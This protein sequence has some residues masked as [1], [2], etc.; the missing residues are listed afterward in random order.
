MKRNGLAASL[1]HWTAA[2]LLLGACHN[3]NGPGSGPVAGPGARDPLQGI[4][5]VQQE[6]S[7][8]GPAATVYGAAVQHA[9]APSEQAILDALSHLGVE[10]CPALSKM[11]REVARVAP[12]HVNIPPKLLDALMAWA[13]LPYPQ[14]RLVLVQLP[15]DPDECHRRMGPSCQ[16]AIESLVQQVERQMPTDSDHVCVGAGVAPAAGGATRLM[17]AVLE[18]T[19]LLE[20]MATTAAVGAQI[21]LA[22][23]LIEGR[24]R[25]TIE[26]VGPTGRMTSMPVSVSVDGSFR[27][28]VPCGPERGV[29]QVEVLAEG[30]HGPE[31]AANFPLH[32]GVS[33]PKTLTVELERI[34][35]DVRPQQLAHANFSYLNEERR[36]RGLPEL[37]WD[38][39]AADVATKHS[40]D[41]ARNGFVGHRS[42]NTGDVRQRFERARLR[43][44]II[45]E[46][47]AR[48]YG[49]KGIHD[50]LMNSPGHRINIL[51]PDVT[52]V[53]IG[54][55]I[56]P[57][58]SNVAGVRRP[59]FATQNFFR[60][61]GTGT[62]SQEQL[63]PAMQSRVEQA[64]KRLGLSAPQ[65]SPHLTKAAGELARI[66]AR[67]RRPDAQW[68]QKLFAGGFQSVDTHQVESADFE[69][70]G[71]IDVW[72]QPR[73][74]AGIGFAKVGRG[75]DARILMVVLI[76]ER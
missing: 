65:W 46:N 5:L 26:V 42:P 10:H 57:P 44:S 70:L 38:E 28:R 1:R 31:V 72:T 61:P 12:D 19:A 63:V 9:L 41:M 40:A 2:A 8:R 52:H 50:S 7:P 55:V 37:Q 22:G 64:R 11:T 43:G 36:S 49:P 58:E 45:R 32:C 34:D 29:H 14:P 3:T 69:A 13:G 59:L 35:P 39:R 18:R 25:P 62:P 74:E 27:S 60:K 20:P 16:A 68:E 4:E 67:G 30:P 54:V 53:G 33:F 76:G 17:A 24:T 73:L 15:D 48:G 66:L 47:V 75:D 23:R 51:A 21:Q 71:S 56:G 6:V